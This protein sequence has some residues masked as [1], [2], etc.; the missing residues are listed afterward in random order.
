MA[1]AGGKLEKLERRGE[2][3]AKAD[4]LFRERCFEEIRMGDLAA[5]LGLAKGTL[6]LY[7]PSKE[8]LFLA[9]LGERLE[10]ALARLYGLLETGRDGGAASAELVAAG[11]A[12]ILAADPALPRLLAESLSVLERRVGFEEAVAFKRSMAAALEEAGGRLSLILPGLSP[13]GGRRYFLYVFS[14]V[15]GLA[16]LTDLSPFMRRVAA[17]PGLE[18]FRL[19]FEEALRS[20]AA[21]LL[22]GLAGGCARGPEGKE[23]PI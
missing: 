23:Q 14:L 19:G 16:A 1:R 21:S 11:T 20:S 15:V 17:A 13:E 10:A 7:F 2:I 3:L 9:L 22:A 12:S 6:Y 18:V 4:E 8:S 5:S